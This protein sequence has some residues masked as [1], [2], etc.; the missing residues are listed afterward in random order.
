MLYIIPSYLRNG[1]NCLPDVTMQNLSWPKNSL[2]VQKRKVKNCKF[3][4]DH[5]L[6]C[7][8]K[9]LYDPKIY[10][11][12]R[13]CRDPSWSLTSSIETQKLMQEQNFSW[14]QNWSWKRLFCNS[15]IG[16]GMYVVETP[17]LIAWLTCRHPKLVVGTFVVATNNGCENKGCHGSSCHPPF[18]WSQHDSFSRPFVGSWD[19]SS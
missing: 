1:P 3:S 16:H 12:K 18:W 17:E 13:T 19:V 15:K 14:P 2:Q 6:G 4:R 10:R 8:S 11:G 7:G 5:K 9:I